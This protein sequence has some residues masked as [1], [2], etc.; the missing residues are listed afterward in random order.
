MLTNVK[1]IIDNNK[2]F[3]VWTFNNFIQKCYASASL[4]QFNFIANMYDKDIE[5]Y[6]DFLFIENIYITEQKTN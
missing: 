1:I 6:K 5:I 4:H 2:I 3:E